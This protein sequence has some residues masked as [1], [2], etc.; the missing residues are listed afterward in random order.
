M[1]YTVEQL[2]NCKRREHFSIYIILILL[3]YNDDRVYN[4][5]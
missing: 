1:N 5:A 3:N 2:C 4:Y